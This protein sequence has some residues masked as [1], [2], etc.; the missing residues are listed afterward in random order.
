LIFSPSYSFAQSNQDDSPLAGLFEFFS[1]LFS[2]G[3]EQPEQ[4]IEF[5][6]AVVIET[7]NSTPTA[8]AGDDQTVMEFAKVTLDGS[9][10]TDTDGD[11]LSYKWTQTTGPEVFTN[12]MTTVESPMFMA[13]EFIE[14]DKILTFELVVVDTSG[15]TSEVDVVIVE[16]TDKD[17]PQSNENSPPTAIA[18]DDQ[19]VM[20]FAKVTL[21]GSSSTDTD[22]NIVSYKWTQFEGA[23]VALSSMSVIM[24]MFDAPKGEDTL[25]FLLTIT[26]DDGAS[27]TDEVK[28]IVKDNDDDDN[29]DDN[30]DDDNKDNDNHDQNK[31]TICHRPPGN[32]DNSHTITVGE[33]AVL[34]HVTHGDTLEECDEDE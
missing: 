4:V 5:E 15:A 24:P 1:Q 23:T 21:D 11:P 10:S 26:D 2:G 17:E 20:E 27:D 34:A 7:S 3:D 29:D 33:S 25:K 22:G 13:P 18:G 30:N 31:V 8:I 19:T 32:P 6:N 9:S 12:S 16:V 28:I 14:E